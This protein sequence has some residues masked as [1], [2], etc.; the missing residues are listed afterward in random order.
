MAPTSKVAEPQQGKA[1]QS[2]KTDVGVAG[3][4][5]PPQPEEI[6]LLSRS[7]STPDMN[8]IAYE[9][10]TE[11]L[12]NQHRRIEVDFPSLPLQY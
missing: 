6:G 12:L 7:Q 2:P 4:G 11:R 8:V 1:E 10:R 5:T 9:S 3:P